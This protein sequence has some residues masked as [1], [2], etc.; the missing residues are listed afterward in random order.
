MIDIE[1]DNFAVGIEVDDETRDDLSGLRARRALEFDIKT[2]RFRIVVQLHRSSSRKLRS[3]NALWTVSPS[4]NVTT[5][6][7]RGR[8]SPGMTILP[9]NEFGDRSRSEEHTSELQ[10]LRHLV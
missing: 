9:K 4:S 7:N 1:P 5:R 2:V 6:R 3:K 8:V 10:S